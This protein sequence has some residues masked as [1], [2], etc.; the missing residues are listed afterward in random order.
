[1]AR[2][3]RME[4]PLPIGPRRIASVGA[5]PSDPAPTL[6]TIAGRLPILPKAAVGRC[7]EAMG[8]SWDSSRPNETRLLDCKPD[9]RVDRETIAEYVDAGAGAP[10]ARHGDCHRSPSPSSGARLHLSSHAT[11]RGWRSSPNALP[12]KR[13]PKPRNITS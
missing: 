1:M 2:V 5:M 11:G 6:S 8:D 7:K 13:Q 10:V 12:L 4:F 3:P 9:V